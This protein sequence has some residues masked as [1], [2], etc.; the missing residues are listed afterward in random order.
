MWFYKTK[1]H[2][3]WYEDLTPNLEGH[4][5]VRHGS[6]ERDEGEVVDEF[7]WVVPFCRNNFAIP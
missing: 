5:W 7:C 4:V 1:S 3:V 6:I 2:K